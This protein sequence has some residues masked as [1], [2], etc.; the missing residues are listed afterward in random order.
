L[1]GRFFAVAFRAGFFSTDDLVV[2]FLV[3]FLARA[4]LARFLGAFLLGGLLTIASPGT[5]TLSESRSG[6]SVTAALVSGIAI[7]PTGR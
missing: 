1:R 5:L 2:R 4:L 6:A 7:A 3:A